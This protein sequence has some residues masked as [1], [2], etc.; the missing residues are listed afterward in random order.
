MSKFVLTFGTQ[1]SY[2]PHPLGAGGDPYG[3]VEVIADDEGAARRR[4]VELIGDK[5]A[6]LYTEEEFF[7]EKYA[8]DD[9]MRGVDY[10]PRGCLGTIKNGKFWK[11]ES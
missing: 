1:Y 4:V 10:H 2:K 11:A 9:G 3:Y 8:S 5:W 7:S 6:F